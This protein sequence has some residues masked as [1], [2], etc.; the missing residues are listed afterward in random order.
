MIIKTIN[1][2]QVLLRRLNAD[3]FDELVDYFRRL[4]PETLR[5]Y[6]PHKFDKQSIIELFEHSGEYSGYIAR[7][8]GTSGIIAYSVIKKG[9]LEH[10]GARLRCYG[11]TPDDKT[12][13]TFAPS[14]ADQ[15]QSQGVGNSLF[16]FMLS[17]LKTEGI[18]RIILWGGVQSDNVKAVNYYIK[19]GFT[20]IGDFQHNGPNYDMILKLD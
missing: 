14:V 11:L 9:Y 18:K 13:C 17:D 2:W 1:D 4:S 20:I 6:G 15:W 5:R 3:D 10:D 16:N 8:L 7:D 12:D 19:I